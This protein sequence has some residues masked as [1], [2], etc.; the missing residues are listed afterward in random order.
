MSDFTVVLADTDELK[1]KLF[2]VRQEVFVVEQEVDPKE[3]FDEF[4]DISRHL[5]ALDSTSNAI[6]SAR[7]RQTDK[8]F[9]LERFAVK[10][11]WR[12]RGVASALVQAVLD[13]ITTQKGTGHYLYMHAQLDAIPLYEKFGFQKRGDIFSECDILHYKMEKLS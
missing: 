11:E 5:V 13:D 3:E 7:W 10:K 1:K 4:E 9:K 2:A 6:G 12:R 8:G